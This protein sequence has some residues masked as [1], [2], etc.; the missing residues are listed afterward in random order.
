MLIAKSALGA[1][2]ISLPYTVYTLGYV[3]ATVAFVFFFAVNQFAGMLLLKSKN[4]SRHSNFSTI[5]YNIWKR[6][7]ARIFGSVII[8]ID[9]FGSCTLDET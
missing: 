6:D 2:I 3:V 7:W 4:L 8:C 9:N 1:G 5:L